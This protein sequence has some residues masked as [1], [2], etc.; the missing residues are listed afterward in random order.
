MFEGKL[1]IDP[2]CK[3]GYVSQFSQVDKPEETTVFDYIGE[4]YIQIQDETASIYAEMET[5]SDMDSLLEKLQLALDAFA[6]IGGDDFESS[7]NKK[8]NLA[9]LMK[10]KDVKVS[11]LSGGEFKLIDG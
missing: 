6:S 8:L 10:L 1:E 3:I 9:N 5:T 11:D 7:M 2:T 4:A